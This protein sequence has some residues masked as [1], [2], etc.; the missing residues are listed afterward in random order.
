MDS[1]NTREIVN[2]QEEA[3]Y[4]YGGGHW[5]I[6]KEE[7]DALMSGKL[8]N[9]GISCDEYGITIGLSKEVIEMLNKR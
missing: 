8:L 3:E 7:F 5:E 1:L 6:T 4:F 9:W 2:S